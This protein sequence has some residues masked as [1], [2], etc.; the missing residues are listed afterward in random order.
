T[1]G[2]SCGSRTCPGWGSCNWSSACATTAT[3][4]RTCTVPVCRSGSCANES[5]METQGCTRST[6]GNTCEPVSCDPYG[7]CQPDGNCG[8]VQYATCRPRICSGGACSN[9]TAYTESRSCP[10]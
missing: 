1:E 9:G 3:Q 2:I 7:P 4:S 6:N 10:R 5:E 8:G